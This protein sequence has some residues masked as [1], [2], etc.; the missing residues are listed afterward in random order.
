MLFLKLGFVG[1][2]GCFEALVF[3]FRQAKLGFGEGPMKLKFVLKSGLLV[4]FQNL[5]CCSINSRR[6]KFQSK[7]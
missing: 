6:T 1:D 3:V 5:G 7:Y 2:R 4:R